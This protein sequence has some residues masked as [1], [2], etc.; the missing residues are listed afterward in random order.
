MLIEKS[1][2]PRD[3]I[4]GDFVSPVTQKELEKLGI[5][6]TAEFIGSNRIKKATV[7]LDGQELISRAVPK[8]E[9]LPD[10]GRVIP[11]IILDKLLLDSACKQGAVLLEGTKAIS[12]QINKE[13]IELLVEDSSGKRTLKARLLIGADGSNSVIARQLRG[14]PP[15]STDRIIAIRGYFEGIE[16]SPDQADLYFNNES[17]PGYCWLFPT[18]ENRANVGIGV[19]L[20]TNPLSKNLRE[21]LFQLIEE[22]PALHNRLKNAKLVGQIHGWPLSTYNPEQ[23]ML[24]DRVMLVGDAAGLIN[25]LNGEGIQYA[26]LS[27]RWAS[28][29]A[30]TCL[31]NDDLSKQAL[32][33][34]K[35]ILEKEL[36][37]GMSIATMI[38]QL[39]RNRSLNPVW[40]GT[41][42]V[43][44]AQAKV[45]PVYADILG[46]ILIGT[47]PQSEAVNVKVIGGT[48][49]QLFVSASIGN[50][51]STIENPSEV[52]K[53]SAEVIQ[54]G[55]EL[56]SQII[57]N[58]LGFFDWATKSAT[59]ALN[60]AA[61]TTANYA[62]NTLKKNSF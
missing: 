59:S 1:K 61:A 16:G 12:Y 8:V 15:S 6:G 2:F 19:A 29:V 3:K 55:L 10:H 46:G 11:R 21:T 7:Y 49:Q 37:Y 48:M 13:N 32:A 51:L 36:N 41:M 40:L 43:I 45:D 62:E 56:T 27:S 52:V 18:S 38:V 39:I 34:Y 57:F 17:F 20:N 22:N 47:I 60:V 54:T 30:G 25:P 9:D 35:E 53:V 4:C 50:M 31:K 42:E 33:P 23:A 5:T 24:D 28:E 26:L 58:P 14:K 44:A